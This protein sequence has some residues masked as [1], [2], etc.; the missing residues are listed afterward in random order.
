MGE[1]IFAHK[2]VIKA[3]ATGLYNMCEASTEVNP[4]PVPDVDPEIF[5]MMLH[6]FYGN[7][8]LP[9]EWI[10]NSKS[11]LKAAG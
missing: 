8:I 5:Q 4:L 10:N 6:T 1:I 9:D 3:Q 11:I 7:L 2:N